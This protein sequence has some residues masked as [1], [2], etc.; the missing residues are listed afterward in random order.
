M[1]VCIEQVDGGFS[2]YQEGGDAVQAAGAGNGAGNS[3]GIPGAS[4]GQA[5]AGASGAAAGQ[6]ATGAEGQTVQ[7]VEE[8]LQIAGSLLGAGG[9]EDD[10]GAAEQADALFNQGFNQARG[11]QL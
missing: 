11:G 2:V 1:K 6:G 4:A 3:S 5:G 10:Q 8:A 9:A 7:T